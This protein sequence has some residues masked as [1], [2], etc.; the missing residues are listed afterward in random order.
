MLLTTV[1]A[2]LLR[3]AVLGAAARGGRLTAG[4]LQV[5][6]GAAP[7]DYVDPAMLFRRSTFTHGIDGL[8]EAV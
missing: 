5:V 7:P 3:M 2:S 6:D 4:P 1:N 8:I